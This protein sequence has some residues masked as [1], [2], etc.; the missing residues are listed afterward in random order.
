MRTFTNQDFYKELL[1][2]NEDND[3][4]ESGGDEEDESE[5]AEFEPT[6]KVSGKVKPKLNLDL[7]KKVEKEKTVSEI[8]KVE[9]P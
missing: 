5:I 2:K 8:D 3:D 4:D 1:K 9:E 6:R 7:I